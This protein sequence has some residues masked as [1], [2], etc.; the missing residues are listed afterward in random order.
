MDER[1]ALS[2][3]AHASW[4]DFI[5][6]L[7]VL[8]TEHVLAWPSLC[9][10]WLPTNEDGRDL[11]LLGTQTSGKA[12]NALLLVEARLTG[13]DSASGEGHPPASLRVVQVRA[14]PAHTTPG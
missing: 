8:F 13:D 2:H 11:L 10:Q 1:A 6:F 3:A 7:Y 12:P 9:V 5:P 4:Q 14:F